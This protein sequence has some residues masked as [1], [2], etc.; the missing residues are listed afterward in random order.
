M[1]FNYNYAIMCKYKNKRENKM[2]T[3]REKIHTKSKKTI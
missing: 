1:V 3:I 2:Q